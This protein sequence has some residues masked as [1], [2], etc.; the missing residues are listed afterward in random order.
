MTY[1]VKFFNTTKSTSFPERETHK[2]IT[3]DEVKSLI[4]GYNVTNKTPSY[5]HLTHPHN[6]NLTCVV[7]VHVSL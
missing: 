3:A 1:N 7:T 6:T 2:N 4:N 5:T